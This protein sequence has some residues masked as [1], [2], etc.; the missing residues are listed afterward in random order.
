[1]T[2]RH[3]QY[4]NVPYKAAQP[5]FLSFHFRLQHMAFLKSK[6]RKAIRKELLRMFIKHGTEVAIGLLTGL[7]THLFANKVDKPEKEKGKKKKT[8]DEPA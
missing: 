2:S 8:P 3:S 1:M 7:A 6:T 4:L 5:A